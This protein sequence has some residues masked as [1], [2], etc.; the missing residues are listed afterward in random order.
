M[1]ENTI[2]ALLVEV[3][4]ENNGTIGW[5]GVE[6]A[7]SVHGRDADIAGLNRIA[8]VAEE[9]SFISVRADELVALRA[10]DLLGGMIP[11]S[12]REDNELQRQ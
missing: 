10:L 6:I 2:A 12:Q 4:A 7:D 8:I 3:I 9:V 5:L 11:Q 1:I